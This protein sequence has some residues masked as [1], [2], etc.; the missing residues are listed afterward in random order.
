M[1]REYTQFVA[2]DCEVVNLGPDT[3]EA[4]RAY[5]AEHDMPFVGLADPDHRVAKVYGQPVRLLKLGRLPLQL[6]VDKL[7]VVRDRHESNSMKDIPEVQ[8]VLA[9]LERLSAD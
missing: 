4:Y 8:S 2:L 7:G 6:I 3:A 9:Q 1:R 5:W